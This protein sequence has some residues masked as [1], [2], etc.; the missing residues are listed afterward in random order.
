MFFNQKALD[1]EPKLRLLESVEEDL[2]YMGVRNWR[3]RF[4]N[5]EQWRAILEEDGVHQGP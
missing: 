3:R 5:R 2:N 1:V 4:Q